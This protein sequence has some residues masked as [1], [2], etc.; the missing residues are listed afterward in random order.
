MSIRVYVISNYYLLREGLSAVISSRPEQ[1][2]LVGSAPSLEAA[3]PAL[4]DSGLHVILLDV[5][6]G[7]GHIPA[8]IENIRAQCDAKILLI[9]GHND[10]IFPARVGALGANGVIDRGTTPELL[11]RAIEKVHEGQVWISRANG[12][13]LIN[14]Q[15][16]AVSGSDKSPSSVLA[17]LT[18][19]ERKVLAAVVQHGGDSGKTI[20]RRLYISES[21]LRNHLTSIYGK[22]DVTSRIGLLAYVMEADLPERLAKLFE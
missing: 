15:T 16:H 4:A 13:R 8:L 1:F 19:R 17:L 7:R 14:A 5:G 20:A 11:L 22:F 2:Q 3:S 18:V 12:A 9:S 10:D 6:D 21:T